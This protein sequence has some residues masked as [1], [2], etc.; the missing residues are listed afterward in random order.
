MKANDSTVCVLNEPY[1]L[2]NYRNPNQ[3]KAETLTKVP[4]LKRTGLKPLLYTYEYTEG[5]HI[6]DRI[7]KKK[8]LFSNS[9]ERW[10]QKYHKSS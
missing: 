4:S 8:D 10:A 2:Q 3:A 6:R 9:V 7:C 1:L 5:M